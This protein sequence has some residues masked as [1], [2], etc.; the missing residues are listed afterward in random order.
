[1]PKWENSDWEKKQLFRVDINCH[2]N[3]KCVECVAVISG[4]QLK[5]ITSEVAKPTP[6]CCN[7]LL[8][9]P[10]TTNDNLNFLQKRQFWKIH[11]K[12]TATLRN[13]PVEKK[14]KY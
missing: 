9:H 5:N 2:I 1:M 6:E 3:P 13:F 4:I 11:V 8:P 12:V 14:K 10:K 7:C